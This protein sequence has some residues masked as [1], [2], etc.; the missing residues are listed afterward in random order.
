MSGPGAQPTIV[1]VHGAFADASGWGPVITRLTALGYPVFAPPNPLRSVIGDGES[2]RTFV[3]TLDGPV[4]LVG[5]SYGGSVITNAGAGAANVRALVSIAGYLPEEG[6]TLAASGALDGASNDLG[7]HLVIRPYPGAP[8]GDG[9]AYIDPAVFHHQF[10]ADLPADVAAVMAVSQRPVA[11]SCLGTP[12]GPAA[13]KTLPTW[14]M[15][16]TQDHAI[17]PDAERAMAARAGATTVEVDSSHVAFISHP[18]ETVDLI[19]AAVE[20]S[21]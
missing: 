8:E 13:W 10:C 19:V 17:P 4:V 20:G 3:S 9:D 11:A 21:A 6:E 1:L 2:L 14:A 7:E 15:V 16:A 12:S 18:D 5:H